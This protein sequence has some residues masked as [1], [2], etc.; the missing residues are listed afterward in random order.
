MKRTTIGG[1]ALIEGV[2]MK[3]PESIAIAVRK[4]DGEIIIDK[5]QLKLNKSKLAKL[6]VIRGIVEFFRIMV[7]GVKALMFS[8]EFVDIE[9]DEKSEP[10]KFDAYLEKLFGNKM[11]D[12]IVYFSVIVSIAFSVGLFILL[13]NLLASILPFNK[14]VASGVIYYNLFE[15]VIRVAIFFGYLSLTSRLKDIQRV[16]QYHGAEHK[17]IHCYEHEEELTVDNVRKYTTKHPRCGTSFIFIVM[18]VSII[19]FAFT[20]WNSI[21]LNILIR[22]VL[23]PFVAGISYEVLKFMGRRTE[24]RIVRAL[25]APGLAF[26]HFTTREPDD[27][28]IEVAIE[29]FNNV[30]VEDKNADIW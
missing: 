9:E 25:S 1:Q 23:I 19:V 8:A 24:W 13:P 10:S 12:A 16:W 7:I 27:S 11:K 26:Q 22:I 2:M 15:G 20:G 28:Q 14:K 6:P 30:L 4:P 17:T 18:I 29:A 5:K 21:W 3:G